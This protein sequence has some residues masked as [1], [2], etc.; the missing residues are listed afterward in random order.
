MRVRY[1]PHK[2][3]L[4]IP[5][6]PP[7]VFADRR[8]LVLVPSTAHGRRP[9]P[10]ERTPVA[11]SSTQPSFSFSA[12]RRQCARSVIDGRGQGGGRGGRDGGHGSLVVR[13]IFS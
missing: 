6:L 7:G 11:S 12:S 1:V 2:P 10:L 5:H 13:M 4:T 9:I 3:F 8:Y